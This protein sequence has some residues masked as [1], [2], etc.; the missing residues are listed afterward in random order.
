M[1]KGLALRQTFML[2]QI[3]LLLGLVYVLI[4]GIREVFSAPTGPGSVSSPSDVDALDSATFAKVL[5]RN[6]YDTILTNKL[7]G[8]ASAYDK[9]ANTSIKKKPPVPEPTETAE[10]T[11]LPLKLFGTTVAGRDDFRSSAMI[12]VRKG[13]AKTGVFYIGQEIMPSTF[14]V[15]VRRK[16][17][18]ID[19]QA[20]HRL[21]LLKLTR[22]ATT[23]PKR[24]ARAVAARAPS[25]ALGRPQMITLD[26]SDIRRRAEE[27]YAR[28]ASTV[29][30]KVV[31]D[32]NGNVKGITTDDIQSIELAN[33][34][35]FQNGDVLVSIN[36]E[37]VTSAEAGASIVRKYQNAS[38]F[39]IGIE[40]DGQS[41]YINYRIR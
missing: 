41:L 12:E 26:R 18:L 10:E 29:D 22:Q 9:Q 32:E 17:V 37:P 40:R 21:E 31:I 4:S 1:L 38:I 25:S 28:I 6:D 24:T 2:V 36:N 34:L 39:R 30:V 23:Q 35:G 14:L 16:E 8:Q 27:E 3:L 13:Q 15:A 7:F 11:K 5:N 20:N 19:N 33:E